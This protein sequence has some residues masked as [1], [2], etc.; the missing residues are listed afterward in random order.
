MKKILFI[1]ILSWFL[2]FRRIEVVAAEIVKNDPVDRLRYKAELVQKMTER[3]LKRF[4]E[5]CAD[6]SV[7]AGDCLI[8]LG[9]DKN[10]KQPC[11]QQFNSKNVNAK[12]TKDLPPGDPI[13]VFLCDA[14][15]PSDDCDCDNLFPPP[16]PDPD[17]DCYDGIYC[18]EVVPECPNCVDICIELCELGEGGTLC[19]CE[20]LPPA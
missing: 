6:P 2:L 3:N 19:Q 7:K 10:I 8:R 18:G 9:L 1:L 12:N 5:E 11:S 4:K 13:C 15:I 16:D 17:P 14:N 20:S